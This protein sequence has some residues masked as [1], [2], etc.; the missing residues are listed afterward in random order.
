MAVCSKLRIQHSAINAIGCFVL[1]I[2]ATLIA[3]SEWYFQEGNLSKPVL[4]VLS[5]SILIAYPVFYINLAL[6]LFDEKRIALRETFLQ[7]LFVIYFI[8][9]TILSIEM[10]GLIYLLLGIEY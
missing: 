10:I 8:V 7:V 9:Q 3:M 6:N 4:Y 1:T 2:A 5:I